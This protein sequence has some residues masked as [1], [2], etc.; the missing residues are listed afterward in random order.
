MATS[1]LTK[2]RI[3]DTLM[4][5]TRKRP[6]DK[7]TVTDLAEACYITR[8]TFYYHFRDIL[9]VFEWAMEEKLKE[10]IE[11]S[12]QLELPLDGIRR[13]L[14]VSFENAEIIDRLMHSDYRKDIERMFV[15]SMQ[16]YF[17]EM[18]DSKKLF[19]NVSRSD[20]E[21][22]VKLLSYAM[23]GLLIDICR[24]KEPDLDDLSEQL[25]RLFSGELLKQN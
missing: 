2:K 5:L 23:V 24:D 1:T 13:M 10:M 25:Y 21:M 22:A 9:D 12:L 4:E 14:S 3:A 11:E 20:L 6:I 16:K 8:Q 19:R 18:I 15:S 7:I 17:K